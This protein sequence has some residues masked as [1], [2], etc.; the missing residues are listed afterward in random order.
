MAVLLG[1]PKTLDIGNRKLKVGTAS[2]CKTVC[3]GIPRHYAADD[4]AV[5][6]HV[7]VQVDAKA[8]VLVHVD[9]DAHVDVCAY[10]CAHTCTCISSYLFVIYLCLYL[11]CTH[12]Y[13]YM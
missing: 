3:G 2:S 8:G 5:H 7:N 11:M 12:I 1:A 13:I 10:V 6:V 4:D 9:V